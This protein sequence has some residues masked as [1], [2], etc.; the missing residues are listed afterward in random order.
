MADGRNTEQFAKIH[1]LIKDIHIAMLTTEGTDGVLHSRPMA[2]QKAEFDGSLWFLTRHN[3]GKVSEIL[4][5]SEVNLTYTDGN[6]SFVSLSGKAEINQDRSKIDELWSPLHKAWFP[7][8]KDDPE[9]TVLVV[10]V[11]EA[12][13]WE[14]PANAIVRNVKILSAALT[15]GKVTAGEH[16][17]VIL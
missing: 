17:K 6:H 1:E 4:H 14:A 16:E 9:I 8:G 15:G 13:Y 10:R 12:E 3:S 11:K 7:E 2:T 5:D